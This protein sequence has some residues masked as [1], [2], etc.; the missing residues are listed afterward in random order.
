MSSGTPT[1]TSSYESTLNLTYDGGGRLTQIADST[2]L[3]GAIVRGFDDLERLTS[4]QSPQGTVSYEYD[5][6]SRRSKMIIGANTVN[7]RYFDDNLI[8]SLTRGTKTVG[9][10]YDGANRPA[11]ETL[12][13]GVVQTYTFDVANEL[14]KISFDDGATN[15][16]VLSYCYDPAGAPDSDV[17]LLGPHRPPGRDDPECD[18]RPCERAEDLEWDEPV[19]RQ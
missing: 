1:C 16:G 12:P 7:Y 3:A 13:N 18:V 5:N 11:T 10:T 17:E 6:A 9:F 14:T 15:Y 19:L 2:P 8:L 4:E